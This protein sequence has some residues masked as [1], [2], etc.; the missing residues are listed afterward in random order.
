MSSV[1][2][3][4]VAEAQAGRKI[5][6]Y[7]N[8]MGLP[9]ISRL[10]EEGL[11]GDGLH[12]RLRRR[13]GRRQHRQGLGRQAA[14]QR[15]EDRAG[16][17]SSRSRKSIKAPGV[18]AFDETRLSVVAMRFDGFINKVMPVTSGTHVRKGEPLMS[19]FG[20]ELLNAGVQ[21]IVEEVTGW[22]G[23]E[24]DEAGNVA[25]V[26]ETRAH[27]SSAPAAGWRTFRCRAEV[28]DEIK[29]IPPRAGLR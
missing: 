22:K 28:I 15:R 2:P 14:A 10:P 11:D 1:D 29:K 3:K 24:R 13:P 23:P 21:L 7:R 5:I 8:P 19:V 18:V 20:Q 27:A 25:G 26:A 6:H 12:P 4:P 17:H 16:R 9:D